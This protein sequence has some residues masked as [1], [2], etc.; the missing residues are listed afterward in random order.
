MDELV[1]IGQGHLIA[2]VVA[3]VVVVAVV[4]VVVVVVVVAAVVVA[5]SILAESK[6]FVVQ[7]IVAEML[8]NLANLELE[9]VV[10]QFV[11]VD[12]D[13]VAA[14]EVVELVVEG[15]RIVDA[16]LV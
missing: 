16:G 3:A 9:I 11:D 14:I 10:G 7:G 2:A 1:E 6:A 5:D 8:N 12:V 15:E 4:V 13:V